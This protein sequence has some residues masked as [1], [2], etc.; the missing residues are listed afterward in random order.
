[1]DLNTANSIVKSFKKYGVE[2]IPALSDDWTFDFNEIF[3]LSSEELDITVPLD[4]EVS[5]FFKDY[6]FNH[7]ISIDGNK[8]IGEFAFSKNILYMKNEFLEAKQIVSDLL[9]IPNNELIDNGVYLDENGERFIHLGHFGYRMFGTKILY[10][11]EPKNYIIKYP[12]S[13]IRYGTNIIQ[14]TNKRKFIEFVEFLSSEDR[15]NYIR[16]RLP[17][18]F[19]VFMR[20]SFNDITIL[21]EDFSKYSNVCFIKFDDKFGFFEKYS[22]GFADNKKDRNTFYEIDIKNFKNTFLRDM[23]N[24]ILKPIEEYSSNIIDDF[25]LN[26]D[27]RN[28]KV[29]QFF[30][31]Y[32]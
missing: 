27:L 11:K 32:I 20:D 7:K 26:D 5:S 2:Y 17:V 16:S 31:D 4:I 8:L 14:K 29:V 3:Y 28:Y 18:F 19:S 30:C 13:G 22:F 1:M 9:I 23:D 6:I 25:V 21:E 15:L 24:G 12:Y 10:R